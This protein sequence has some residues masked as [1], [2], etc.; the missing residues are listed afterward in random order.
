MEPPREPLD[1]A[2]PQA[3]DAADRRRRPH[4]LAVV[5][6]FGFVVAMIL[7]GAGADRLQFSLAK[8]VAFTAAFAATA[9]VVFSVAP[10]QSSGCLTL[11]VL[12]LFAALVPLGVMW[13]WN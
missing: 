2:T 9:S 11:A 6:A 4:D 1:Y 13:F 10:R 5:L 8:K 7:S 3:P 12:W